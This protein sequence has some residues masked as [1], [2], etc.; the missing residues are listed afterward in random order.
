MGSKTTTTNS[1]GTATTTPTL[2]GAAVQPVNDYYAQVQNTF[3]GS[4][5]YQFVTPINDLQAQAMLG[6]TSLGG[7]TALNDA[8][9]MTLKMLGGGSTGN[10]A[11]AVEYQASDPV[12]LGPA[13]GY[14]SGGTVQPVATAP[15]ATA[16]AATAPTATGGGALTP[17][18]AAAVNLAP[19]Q[20]YSAATAGSAYVPRNAATYSAATADPV[21]LGSAQG[22]NLANLPTAQTYNALTAAG[23]NLGATPVTARSE[24]VLDNL[25]AYMN[26]LTD[27][28]VN[29]TLS[30]LDRNTDR[31]MAQ[32]DAEAAKNRALGGSRYGLQVAQTATEQAQLRAA[33]EA[34]LRAQAWQQAANLS[35]YDAT[36]RQNTNFF[37][38]GAQNSRAETLARLAQ[39]NAMFNTGQQNSA[40]QFGANAANQF[41]MAGFDAQNAA[42]QF[43]AAQQNQFALTDAQMRLDNNQFNAAQS[44]TAQ[45]FSAGEANKYALAN[46]ELANSSSQFNA[47]QS[48]A[49]QQFSAN[50]ANQF[51]LNNAQLTQD[52]NQFNAGQSNDLAQFAAQLQ[53]QQQAQALDAIG[54]YAD[55]SSQAQQDQIN[56]LNTQL[57]MGNNLYSI[58]DNYTQAPL[59]YLDAYSTALNP[60]LLGATSGQTVTTNETSTA[61]QPSGLLNSLISAGAQLGSALITKSERRVKRDIE[62]I[63]TLEDGLGVYN[64]RYIWDED[65]APLQTGVMVDEVEKLRP[66]ALGPVVDGIQ[67]VNYGEL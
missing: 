10:I 59:E 25:A 28:L 34:Q 5:P 54:Q 37:N 11:P 56:A 9:N 6:S 26:P 31:V 21:A 4:D 38:A 2:L 50:A 29:N 53:L 61:K 3:G 16:P 18:L 33:M 36:N 1:T 8:A 23:A 44:N 52:N 48:N 41:G 20:A 55:I 57:A 62:Q 15:A 42:N 63:G 27:N 17:A 64:F 35:Q 65:N 58:M 12:T 19:A 60:S 14:S 49:A 51:A 66:W 7:S 22:Y 39:E 46:A 13:M 47:A 43:L 32:M 24:S 40:L 67:T 30:G 45:Q